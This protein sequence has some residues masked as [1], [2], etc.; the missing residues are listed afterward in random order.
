MTKY[1][2]KLT[3][4]A[5]AIESESV[6]D[7]LNENENF[8]VEFLKKAL[9]FKLARVDRDHFLR[10]QLSQAGVAPETIA[11]ALREGTT[12]ADIPP[13]VLDKIANSSINFETRNSTYLSMAA[14]VGGA[15]TLAVALPSDVTQYYIHAFRIMQKLAYVY[16][17]KDFIREADDV[18]DEVLGQFLM[19][20]GVMIGVGGANNALR[21]FAAQVAPKMGR[22]VA[23]Q[24]LTK[25]AWYPVAKQVLKQVGLKLTKDMTG[26]AVQKSIPVVGAFVGGSITYVSLKNQADRLQ[27]TLKEIPAPTSAVGQ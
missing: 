24:A 8:A 3:T 9:R 22:R 27:R 14:G 16:G 20:L 12:A 13:A 4:K 17:W 6:T 7:L 23:N 25:T 1:S 10:S 15:A 11:I 26:K 5:G 2:K 21:A 19:L 18:T